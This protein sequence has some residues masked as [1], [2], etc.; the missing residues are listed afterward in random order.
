MPI[1]SDAIPLAIWPDDVWPAAKM[2]GNGAAT[3]SLCCRLREDVEYAGTQV[4][5]E[6]E[7]RRIPGGD[8]TADEMVLPVLVGEGS[9]AVR[10]R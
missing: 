4:V 9:A 6:D 8:G 3:I 2:L 5:R 1:L 10:G 7:M